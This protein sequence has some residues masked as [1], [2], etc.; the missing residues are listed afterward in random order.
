[1][2]CRFVSDSIGVWQAHSDA[3]ETANKIAIEFILKLGVGPLVV[4]LNWQKKR[5]GSEAECSCYLY[6]LKICFPARAGILFTNMLYMSTCCSY[7]K[8]G[9]SV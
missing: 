9:K 2:S 8:T 4:F 5:S 1:M 7:V 6:Q 3:N